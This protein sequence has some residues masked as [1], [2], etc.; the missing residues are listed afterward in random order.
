MWRTVLAVIGGLVAWM[1]VVTLINLGIRQAL[2]GYA[3]AEPALDFTLTM[4]IAR[5][6]MAAVASIAAGAVI[7][8]IAPA[9]K[10][11]PWIVGGA[12]LLFFLPVH[13]QIWPRLPVWYHLFFLGT[14]PLFF[15]LG[16]R[17]RGAPRARPEFATTHG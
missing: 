11:A 2:P 1:A 4:M 15:A 5:L 7:R 13:I 6:A 17:L 16:A 14:L 12:M 10:A 9:S 3:A 8:S